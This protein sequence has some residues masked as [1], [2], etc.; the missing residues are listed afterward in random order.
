MQQHS[1]LISIFF[2]FY[3]GLPPQHHRQKTKLSIINITL[4]S[5]TIKDVEW[6][7]NYAAWISTKWNNKVVMLES[8]TLPTNL[9]TKTTSY[10]CLVIHGMLIVL[11]KKI[12]QMHVIKKNCKHECNWVVLLFLWF[13]VF[14]CD[15]ILPQ[16]GHRTMKISQTIL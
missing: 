10:H 4:K 6:I 2:F 11:G 13:V 14:S 5:I 9:A 16:I 7:M 3:L 12:N 15:L 1:P 8:I